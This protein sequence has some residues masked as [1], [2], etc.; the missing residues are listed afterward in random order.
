MLAGLKGGQ[1]QAASQCR[2]QSLLTMSRILEDMSGRCASP[3]QV[4]EPGLQKRLPSQIVSNAVSQLRAR[5]HV[6][7]LA[8]FQ[9]LGVLVEH[10][11][12]RLSEG[13][14][15]DEE[16]SVAVELTALYTNARLRVSGS[17]LR[18]G[19]LGAQLIMWCM[20]MGSSHRGIRL[21]TSSPM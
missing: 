9:R 21:P 15:K 19:N 20:L 3:G 10:P 2:S 11:R 14:T 5:F 17:A 4:E 1:G 16:D 18:V 13:E 6:V 8:R 12:A 7:C